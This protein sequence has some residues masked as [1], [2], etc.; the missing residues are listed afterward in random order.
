[1]KPANC[2]FSR[3]LSGKGTLFRNPKVYR[4][5][6][7]KYFN[8]SNFDKSL[9][10]PTIFNCDKEICKHNSTIYQRI[11]ASADSTIQW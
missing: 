5:V 11:Y 4:F 8:P 10:S 2:I 6:D 7:V 1:M 3:T 9:E